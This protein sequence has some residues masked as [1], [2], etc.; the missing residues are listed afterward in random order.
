MNNCY[1]VTNITL[2]D[3]HP[4]FNSHMNWPYDHGNV[5]IYERK[6]TFLR[7]SIPTSYFE[8]EPIHNIMVKYGLTAKIFMM[9]PGTLYNWHRDA[10]RHFAINLLLSDDPDYLTVFAHDYPP[11]ERLENTKFMYAPITRLVYKPK[12][13]H[14]FNAQVPHIAFNYSNTNRYLLTI[15]HYETEPVASYLGKEAD[16][17]MYFETV[18]DLASQGLICT[19]TENLK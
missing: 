19:P 4:I 15:A 17:S 13:F 5:S 3:T 7:C 9:E 1:E 11:S 18:K 14:I 8:G 16:S 10:W 2:S 6:N 12:T